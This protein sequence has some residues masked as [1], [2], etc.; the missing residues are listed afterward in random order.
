MK[1]VSTQ[2]FIESLVVSC[3]EAQRTQ[4]IYNIE[5]SGGNARAYEKAERR[6]KQAFAALNRHLKECAQ[7]VA[8]KTKKT[9]H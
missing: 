5:P 1:D 2:D 8:R 6:E 9:R 3:R 4:D 7:F